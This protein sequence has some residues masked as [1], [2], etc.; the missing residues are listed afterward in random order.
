MY[1]NVASIYRISLMLSILLQS[2]PD[3][4][5]LD[6]NDDFADV[7]HDLTTTACHNIGSVWRDIVVGEQ[8]EGC[9]TRLEVTT[10]TPNYTDMDDPNYIP[11]YL[12]FQLL[13]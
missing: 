10:K 6:T 13:Y 7:E 12:D 1:M 8:M 4:I 9:L 5:E 11:V 3:A 2:D